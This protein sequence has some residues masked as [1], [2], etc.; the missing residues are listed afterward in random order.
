MVSKAS[1]IRGAVPFREYRRE[2]A[3][4]VGIGKQ[5]QLTIRWDDHAPE[6]SPFG[7]KTRWAEKGNTKPVREGLG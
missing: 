1:Q 2:T 6:E 5:L 3:V 4:N 7:V